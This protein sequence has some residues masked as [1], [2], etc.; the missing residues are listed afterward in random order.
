MKTNPINSTQT[1]FN[2][3]VSPRFVKSMQGFYN[4]G[5]NRK[6]NIYLLNQKIEEYAKFGKENYTIEMI[7]KSGAL[8]FEYWLVATKDNEPSAR[9]VVLA[10]RTAYRKIVNKFMNM[11][12]GE[13]L[14]YFRG[15]RD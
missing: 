6:Q 4:N 5:E 2:A 14:S 9:Q 8:G 1:N 7:Q 10:T 15:V 11:K 3:K 12:K 13:F